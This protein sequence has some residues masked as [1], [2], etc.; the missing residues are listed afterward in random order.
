MAAPEHMKLIGTIV[1]EWAH[2]EY[3]RF[4]LFMKLSGLPLVEAEAVF[5]TLR[6]DRARSE[7]LEALLSA[8]IKNAEERKPILELHKRIRNTAKR[9]ND[10]GHKLVMGWSDDGTTISQMD[11]RQTPSLD[12]KG[13][14]IESLNEIIREILT[15]H[16]DYL[17]A[18]QELQLPPRTSPRKSR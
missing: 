18:I 12:V 16:F 1:T 7:M 4:T 8:V 14:T 2:L 17:N 15:L 3:L 6:A 10:F 9:R 5:F 13:L 11:P